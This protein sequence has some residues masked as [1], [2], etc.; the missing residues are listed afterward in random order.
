MSAVQLGDAVSLLFTTVLDQVRLG[1]VDEDEE[2]HE[3][4][5]RAYWERQG[6]KA[7]V[8]MADELLEVVKTLDPA[9]DLKYN[10]FYI[11]LAKAGQP[12]NFVILRPKKGFLRF[13]PRLKSTPET[14]AFL[15]SAEL[16]VMDYDSRWGRYRIRLQ[17]GDV[18]K[19]RKVLTEVVART[20]AEWN[21]D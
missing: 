1:L 16:D 17:P 9:L 21:T 7:T 18:E 13:E 14:Q 15:E 2:V 11:G 3:T 4:T 12:R 20:F 6:T 8:A 10:K 5:D 19:Y